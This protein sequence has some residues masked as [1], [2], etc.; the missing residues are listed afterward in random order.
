MSMLECK[1]LSHPEA[2]TFM[3]YMKE[4]SSRVLEPRPAIKKEH[5]ETIDWLLNPQLKTFSAAAEHLRKLES[6]VHVKELVDCMLLAKCVN[7]IYSSCQAE[8]EELHLFNLVIRQ[9][10]GIW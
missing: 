6:S 7:T 8:V 2:D 10:E 5:L 3:L 9:D 4:Q 1:R